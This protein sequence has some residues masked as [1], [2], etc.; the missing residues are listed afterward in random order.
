MVSIYIIMY[1]TLIARLHY[2]LKLIFSVGQEINP[3]TDP[4]TFPYIKISSI[5][6]VI[7]VCSDAPPFAFN[8]YF[9]LF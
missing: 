9:G 5:H 8:T 6:I 2:L 4:L 7:P 3:P 1:S